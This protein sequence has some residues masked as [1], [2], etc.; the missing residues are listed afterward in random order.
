MKTI[1][2]I[3]NIILILFF[4][5]LTKEDTFDPCPSGYISVSALGKCISIVDL[6]NSETVE[7]KT[8]NLLYL[9]SNNEGKINKDNY[10][11]EIY[12]LL[13]Y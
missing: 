9:A 2:Q 7:L 11:L 1:S 5:T 13:I 8:Q 4:F 10:K 12:N 6:L 3:I